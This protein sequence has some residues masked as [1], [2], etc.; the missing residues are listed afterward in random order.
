MKNI[1]NF[2]YSIVLICTVCANLHAQDN[3]SG[4]VTATFKNTP[5]TIVLKK[6]SDQTQKKIYFK[7]AWFQDIN[8]TG[9]FK[10]MPLY[11]V[12]DK[13]LD[14][15]PLLHIEINQIFY[16]V[17]REL[18]A[19]HL[20]ELNQLGS[21]Y[22]GDD[23]INYIIIG[24]ASDIG[25]YKINRIT[26]VVKDGATGESLVG[27]T[28]QVLNSPEY[29]VSGY[30]GKYALELPAGTYQIK[31]S[32]VGF[33]SQLSTIKILGPGK[34]DL[35]LFEETHALTEVT[36]LSD[37]LNKNVSRDQ[38]SI[39]EMSAKDIKQLPSLI[40]ERDIIKSF[41]TMPGVK[42]AGEF[43]SGINVRG[44]GEDQNLYLLENAPLFNTSHVMGLLSAVNPDAVTQVTLYKGHIPSNYGE[45]V[46]SVMDINFNGTNI[47]K[48]SAK[49]GIGIY[50]SRLMAELPFFKNKVTLKLGGR[51]SYSDWLL[52][53]LPDYYLQNSAASF[54]DLNGVLFINLKKNPI[55]L[56]AYFSN[57]K[58][59]YAKIQS[60]QYGNKLLSARWQHIFG[61]NINTTVNLAYSNY[62]V[63]NQNYETKLFSNQVQSDITYL[64]GKIKTEYRG[65]YNQNLILG[66]QGIQYQINPG[67]ITP[68]GDAQV[69]PFSTRKELG[70]E[71]SVFI[72]DVL[73]LS[74]KI[75]LQV[76][77]RFTLYQYLLTS[78][79]IE[80]KRYQGLEPRASFKYQLTENNS[81]K[82][83]FNRNQQFITLLSYTS[84][85]T[86]DD[87][88]KLADPDLKPVIA[89][90]VALGYYQNFH[91]NT[92]E[93]SAE[94]YYKKLQHLSDYKNGAVLKLNNQV[95]SELLHVQG[96]NYGL[97]I[98]LKKS[99]G[100]LFG[101][102]AYTFSRALRAT[103]GESFQE[104][105]NNNQSYPSQF[106]IPHDLNLNLN[107]KINRRLRFGL[108]FLYATGRP[109]TLPEYTYNLGNKDLVYFSD[110]N[111]YRLPD[112][113]RL[114]ISM[115]I[116]ESLKIKKKWKGI[117][118]FS[119]L[120][121]YARKNAYSIVYKKDTPTPEN[122]YQVFSLYKM[123]LIGVPFPTVTYNFIF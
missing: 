49:G 95:T 76:G 67:E 90:Q 32:S 96:K 17:P 91:N 80:L 70:R 27:A 88:W 50:S 61:P 12:L 106:D 81:V 100:N 108:N 69:V 19:Q 23:F 89:D 48:A 30:T 72:N 16:I 21:N 38:M 94:L 5:L 46:S 8:F 120:N 15:T 34:L 71:F 98:M 36:I 60:Y 101:S 3:T 102:V 115:S 105:I 99:S 74:P 59:E 112:Y 56:F 31:T 116:D 92:L 109:V 82:A 20:K 62:A 54:A 113:H 87:V 1:T 44:G 75:T 123:Y 37:K 122:N 79:N 2:G 40:G 117:W 22:S 66:I 47:S 42:T 97:E 114:D 63:T 43:G 10:D 29:G 65:L 85:S 6:L 35:E 86:P 55:T 33:E 121:V 4:R 118:T 73:T 53:K 119:L 58:F 18:V 84:I 25:K 110:R 28:V 52:T 51:A 68:I 107:Y 39:V 57:D 7:E 111:K 24:K 26:G 103:D 93:F 83:S 41:T 9:N 77:L 14:K 13:I 78:T 45:R 11:I 64:S 104:Q